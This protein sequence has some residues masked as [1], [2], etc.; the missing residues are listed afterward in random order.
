MVKQK[1]LINREESW[2]SFNERVLQEAA[3]TAVPLIE[4]IKFLGIFSNNLDEFFRVRVA[5]LRRLLDYEK[6]VKKYIGEKPR[7]ML[8]RIQSIV[9]GFQKTFDSTYDTIKEALAKENIF[10]VNEKEL[11]PNQA[12]YVHRLFK[13]SIASSI[14]P[15]MLINLERFPELTD[16]SIYFAV[17]LT[18]KLIPGIQDYALIEIPTSD[19]SRF[20]VLPEYDGKKY[21][22]LLDDVIRFCLRDIFS[23]LPYDT[24]EAYTIKITR[25]AELD[26]DND[27]SESLLEKISKGVHMRSKGQPVRFV[28]DA[29]IAPDLLSF[30]IAE[31]SLDVED[32]LLAGGRYHNF[33]DFVK[34]PNLGGNALINEPLPPVPIADLEN[35]TSILS[36][37]AHRDF[38]LHYPYHN[39]SYYIQMLREAAIDPR[40][41]AIKITLYRVATESRVVRALINAAQN[42]KEV[43]VV[44]ELRARF[45]EKANIY[46]SRQM[47]EAGIKVIF[48]VPGLKV[49]SKMTLIV[50]EEG[51]K[52]QKYC[53][54]STGNFHEGNANLYTDINLF[55]ADRRITNEID[56]VFTFLEYNYK[57]FSYKHLLVSPVNM[58]RKLYSLIDGEIANVKKK[59]PAYILC[60][61]NNLVDE[62][63]IRK[64]YQASNAGVKIK[65]V[66]RGI[67]SLVPGIPGQSAN[68]EVVSVVDRF[69]EHSR[70]FIFGNNGNELCF[71]SSAD[72]MTRN[73]DYRVEVATPIYDA[74]LKKELRLVIDAALRDN[75]KAR[76]VNHK[77]NNVFKK[78][79][80]KPP[81]RSQVELHKYYVERELK[82]LKS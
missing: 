82:A 60:K 33:K 4:R 40:V 36:V 28:Y 27:I 58:R 73:L 76:I 61:I 32:N 77:Q 57:T 34:F 78:E 81:Y 79:G 72:W 7:K 71:I 14:A 26:V 35:A 62:E 31:M 38:M 54:V 56:K 6:G 70:I 25:D 23:I 65:L 59:L 10:I 69:L 51:G 41:K 43:T 42:G 45:D 12:L 47:E 29:Q 9:I 80:G 11:S 2:L 68:I 15:V 30:I 52:E 48:G 22:I 53:T 64:L 19:F 3:D 21:I 67:C 16:K 49:H 50:R 5:T 13:E 17:R 18:K 46:W 44:I 20:I 63:V 39:F 75:V 55:T 24:F 37:I 1:E 66:V 74:D 8:E